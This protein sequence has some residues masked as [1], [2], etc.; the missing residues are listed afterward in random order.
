MEEP[1]DMTYYFITDERKLSKD[2]MLRIE[3]VAAIEA[4]QMKWK[5]FKTYNIEKSLV[6]D[7][8]WSV[9]HTSVSLN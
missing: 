9:W 8:W 2:D 3:R 5:L 6:S 1:Q 4:A 7:D